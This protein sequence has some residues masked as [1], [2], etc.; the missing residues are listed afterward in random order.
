MANPLTAVT[1]DVLAAFWAARQDEEREVEIVLNGG[2][3]GPTLLPGTRLRLRCH[4]RLPA[5]GEIV[6][7]RHGRLLVV[8]RLQA[9]VGPPDAPRLVCLGDG[10]RLPDPPVP[11]E[12]AVGTIVAAA[13]LPRSRRLLFALRHPRRHLRFLLRRLRQPP[14]A[15]LPGLENERPQG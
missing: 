11:A 10:N 5:L 14:F 12:A 7:C 15:A 13:P 4:R 3:M 9:I 2:S 8:H 1:P 6:A